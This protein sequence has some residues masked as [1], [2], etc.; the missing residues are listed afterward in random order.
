M[1]HRASVD[2]IFEYAGV[3]NTENT[4]SFVFLGKVLRDIGRDGGLNKN[5]G[6]IA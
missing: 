2:E 5:T 6:K 3:K 4:P 1:R